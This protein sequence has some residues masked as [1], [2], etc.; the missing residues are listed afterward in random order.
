MARHKLHGLRGNAFVARYKL[1]LATES[2]SILAAFEQELR[3]HGRLSANGLGR[4]AMAT[5]IPLTL[6][7]DCL[8]SITSNR[9]PTGTW[10]RLRQAGVRAR[11]IGVEWVDSGNQEEQ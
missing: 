5:G 6:L 9:Y 10:E 3:T 1:I 4:I 11:D 8:P 7:D 2:E